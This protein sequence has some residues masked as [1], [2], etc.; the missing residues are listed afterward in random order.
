MPGEAAAELVATVAFEAMLHKTSDSAF[1]ALFHDLMARTGKGG[2]IPVQ[3]SG[4][5]GADGL[6]IWGGKLYA[7]YGSTTADPTVAIRKFREDFRSACDNRGGEFTEFVFV[8]N[9]TGGAHPDLTRAIAAAA[10]LYPDVKVTTWGQRELTDLFLGL[11]AHLQGR[12][13]G[14]DLDVTLLP[15][16]GIRDVADLLDSLTKQVEQIHADDFDVLPIPSPDKLDFN[17]IEGWERKLLREG[18]KQTSLVEAY[19]RDHRDAMAESHATLALSSRYTKLRDHELTPTEIIVE[20]R[21]YV[22]GGAASAAK[23]VAAYTVLAHFFQRCH[24][25]ENPPDVGAPVETG[26]HAAS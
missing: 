11:E 7:C 15:R 1:E 17:R 26:S 3:R 19:Y 9:D 22:G 21:I 8:H 16:T 2:Y 20:L 25:F 6:G 13:L 4:D 10:K 24:I 12:V 23:L 14:K 18:W 5:Q